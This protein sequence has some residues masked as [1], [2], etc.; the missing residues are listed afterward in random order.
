M[1]SLFTAV[2]MVHLVATLFMTVR[3]LELLL[4]GVSPRPGT[5]ERSS[6]CQ[7]LECQFIR[8]S[9]KNKKLYVK[10]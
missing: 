4:L 6:N 9:M 5:M 2:L 1:V 8:G 10:T 7:R 3:S